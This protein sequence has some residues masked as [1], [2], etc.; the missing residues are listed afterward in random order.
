M[1][2]VEL[3]S[4]VSDVRAARRRVEAAGGVLTYEGELTDLR[5]ADAAGSLVKQ[6]HVLRLRVYQR[7]GTK[8]GHCDWKGPTLY[9][10]GYK[11]REEVSTP[12]GDTDT[13]A[14]ILENLGF[15]VIRDI[16]RHIAQYA[17]SGG[18]V[19]FEEYPRMDPLVEVEG[20]PE[21]IEKAI[22]ATGLPRSGFNSDRLPDFVARF[23]ARTGLKAALSANELAGIY[24]YRREDA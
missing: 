2:E 20:S 3:K 8:E 15:L 1:R 7:D 9:E 13:F 4:V 18:I 21:A 5:Y 22:L 24:R 6:D 11:V 12:V 14:R 17:I 16:E 23:E 10:G 19:R